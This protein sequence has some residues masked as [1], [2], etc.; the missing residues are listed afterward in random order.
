MLRVSSFQ[1]ADSIDLKGFKTVF[2][3]KLIYADTNELFFITPTEEYIHVF[4]YG[5]VS[6]FNYDELKVEKVEPDHYSKLTTIRLEET[7]YHTQ[8]LE[9]KGSLDL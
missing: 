6:F 2:P 3:A 7:N 4:R 8:I 1:I 5:I 9:R